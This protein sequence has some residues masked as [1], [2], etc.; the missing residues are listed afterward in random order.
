MRRLTACLTLVLAWLAGAGLSSARADEYPSKPVRLIVGFTAGAAGDVLA[1]VIAADLG[2]RLGQA[3]VVED[4]PGASSNVA[5]EYVARAPNDGYTL[6]LGTVANVTNAAVTPDLHVDFVNDFAPIGMAAILPVL[7]VVH[8]S[9]HVHSLPELI[10]LVKTKPNQILYG[11]TGVG[12]TP[13]LA[14]ELLDSLAG[15]KMVH[16]PYQGSPAA[17]AD[18]IAGRTQVMFA[19][20]STVLPF[21]R[22]G[23]LVALATAAPQRT[24]AAPDLPTTAELGMPSLDASIWFGIMTPAGVSPAIKTKLATALAQ[25]MRN[26]E[27][28][29]TLHLQG[30][31]PQPGS[32]EQFASYIHGEIQKWSAVASTAGLRK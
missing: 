8:P 16:V 31:V 30:F 13:H 6:L 10:A 9:L 1:R 7:L 15:I 11:S 28:L 19:S 18:L 21:V 25:T 3:V 22:S 32:P 24:D 23:A 20:A 14:G 29:A 5:T 12:T 2:K 4:K 27:V 17:V 26:D